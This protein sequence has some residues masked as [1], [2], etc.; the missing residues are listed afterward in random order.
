MHRAGVQRMF[1]VADAQEAGR[2]LEGF[3]PEARHLLQFSA[4]LERAV[5][6]AVGDDVLGQRR[7]EAGDIGEQLLAGGVEFHAHAVDAAHHHVVEAALEGG[8]IHVVLVLAHAD[9]FGI[10]LHQFRQRVHEPAADGDRAAHGEVLVGKFLAGHL[11]GGVD[12]GAAFVDHDHRDGGGQLER[13]DERLGLA[14]RPCRCRWR[15]PRSDICGSCP[16]PPPRL[17]ALRRAEEAVG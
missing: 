9:G 17:R 5:L 10:D 11:G 14:A 6:V 16:A 7:A 2:L 3:G 8:L 13:L 15:W 4:R 1:A 12:R